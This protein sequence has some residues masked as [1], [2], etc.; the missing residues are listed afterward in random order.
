M[1]RLLLI[2]F[3]FPPQ[4]WIGAQRPYGLAKYLVRY[5]WKPVI[6]TARV[7]GRHCPEM[8]I[9]ETGYTDVIAVVKA[10]FG[11]SPIRDMHEQLGITVSKNYSYPS[12][13][14]K[15]I[16]YIKEAVAFPDE[17][18]GWYNHAI[19]AAKVLLKNEKVDAM[20]STSYPV[21]SHLIARRLKHEFGIPWAADLR[22]LWTQNHYYSKSPIIKYFE[23]KME[24]KTLSDAD[25]LVTANPQTNVLADLHRHKKIVCVTNGYDEE[26]FAETTFKLSDKLSLTY[27]GVL[28]NGKRDPSMLF[29]VL[30]RLISEKMIERDLIE[31]NFFGCADRWLRDEVEKYGLSAIVKV[32]GAI[33]RDEALRKQR[34]SQILLLLLWDNAN[35]ERIFP[36]KVFEYLGTRRPIVAFGGTGGVVCDL[37][38]KTKAGRFARDEETLREVILDYYREFLETGTL[39]SRR[40]GE[41]LNYTHDFMAKRYSDILTEMI[42]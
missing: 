27:T 14:S 1:K 39:M 23:R 19:K 41:C 29:R 9:I 42:T 5:G 3:Y 15:L 16:K 6:L 33:S 2:S 10:K 28:Y 20:I 21:T 38:E 8:E 11:F 30:G 34:E 12:L 17:Q 22:D 13:K 40:D 37:L 35:E 32:Y 24:L 25:I 18:I 26:Q 36:G 7:A 4:A 31:I